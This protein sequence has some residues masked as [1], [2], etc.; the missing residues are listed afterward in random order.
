MLN[1]S[2][3]IFPKKHRGSKALKKIVKNLRR[4]ERLYKKFMVICE[5]HTLKGRDVSENGLSFVVQIE[6]GLSF[7]NQQRIM[8]VISYHLAGVNYNYEASLK[9]TNYRLLSAN[10]GVYG[11]Q[12]IGIKLM[13]LHTQLIASNPEQ[14]PRL[15]R[16][17]DRVL[18]SLSNPSTTRLAAEPEKNDKTQQAIMKIRNYSVD[19][20]ISDELFREMV[21]KIANDCLT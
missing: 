7:L 14:Y 13:S 8:C 12:I 11:C 15:R 1:L 2:A 9:V 21:F 20:N 17:A 4:K 18:S 3:N 10:E 19:E 5:E 6:D 16:A